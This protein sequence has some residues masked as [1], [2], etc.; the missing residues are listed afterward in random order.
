MET[1]HREVKPL[2]EIV[3][4]FTHC[5][6]PMRRVVMGETTGK[7]YYMWICV[8]NDHRERGGFVNPEHEPKE[9]GQ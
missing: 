1:E 2:Q 6:R 7:P 3:R 8:N 5:N 9:G 4:P